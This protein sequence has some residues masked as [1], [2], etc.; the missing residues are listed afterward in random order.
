MEIGDRLRLYKNEPPKGD[1][2]YELVARTEDGRP[3][4]AKVDRYNRISE[5]RIV[6]ESHLTVDNA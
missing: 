4:V 6:D 1:P 2:G 3:I 5:P